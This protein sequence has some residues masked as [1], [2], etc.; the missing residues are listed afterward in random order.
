MYFDRIM[1][2]PHNIGALHWTQRPR[3]RLLV[4]YIGMPAI[5]ALLHA[6]H[7]TVNAPS[8]TLIERL[9]MV[10]PA[11]FF[12]WSVAG[13]IAFTVVTLTG[14]RT[15]VQTAAVTM[16]SVIAAQTL[17]YYFLGVY[18]FIMRDRWPWAIGLLQ[19]GLPLVRD[20]LPNFLVSQSSGYAYLVFAVANIGYRAMAPG[21]RYLGGPPV[22]EPAGPAMISPAAVPP[23]V[24]PALAPKFMRKVR[25]HLGSDLV[26]VAAEE[27]YIRVV[28]RLGS[29]LILYR[30]G[31]ALEEL[32]GLD[33][34]RVHRS[35]WICWGEVQDIE[36]ADRS[37]RIRM[38]TG[39]IV[40]V[41]RSNRG[42]CERADRR[43][44]QPAPSPVAAGQPVA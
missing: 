40:P 23:T 20:S 43:R 34:D 27:H 30:F 37:F 22:Y 2:Q 5:S 7:A 44:R 28:T 21:A 33:G 39:D 25:P 32:A 3:L 38:K 24:Q 6:L 36:Q 1:N 31:D 12:G 26:L 14:A 41:S 10:L 11:A 42:L 29:D 19:P 9:F 13:I 17:F 16:V 35:F 18:L 4:C 8:M 15:R